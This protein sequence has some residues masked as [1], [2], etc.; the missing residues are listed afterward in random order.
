MEERLAPQSGQACGL[1]P[2]F[3]GSQDMEECRKIAPRSRES[4]HGP[5]SVPPFPTSIH[6]LSSTNGQYVRTHVRLID[7]IKFSHHSDAIPRILSVCLI[8]VAG[9]WGNVVWT[10]QR[11]PRLACIFG[12]FF[13]VLAA[14]Q[15]WSQAMG[16]ARLGRKMFPHFASCPFPGSDER[17]AARTMGIWAV[18]FQSTSSRCHNILCSV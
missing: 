18:E 15:K 3:R 7:R 1:T 9:W 17:V 11:L 4:L 13:D 14:P 6:R 16:R 8:K 2:I 5:N 10:L 12:G